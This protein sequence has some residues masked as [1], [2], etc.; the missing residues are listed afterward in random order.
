ME[1]IN[2]IST[3]I[4]NFSNNA[5]TGRNT[6][7]LSGAVPCHR[8]QSWSAGLPWSTRLTLPRQFAISPAF[9]KG[10]F[11]EASEVTVP[12]ISMTRGIVQSL[13]LKDI[14][15]CATQTST[16]FSTPPAWRSGLHISIRLQT[17]TDAFTAGLIHQIL[18]E[19]GFT[20]P[21]MVFPVS[22]VMLRPH[23]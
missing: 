3:T 5:N 21:E 22:S 23:R 15:T 12:G 10:T 4:K 6:R 1:F 20:P 9:R 19:R 13:R 14:C 18:A 7:F 16:P 2:H 17:E 11:A 8:V